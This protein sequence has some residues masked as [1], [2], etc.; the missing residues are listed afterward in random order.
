MKPHKP[1]AKNPVNVTLG[2]SKRATQETFPCPLCVAELDLRSSRS[3]KPYCVCNTCG[4]QV[5]FRGKKGIA[6]L[7]ELVNDRNQLTGA[8]T[9]AVSTVVHAFNRLEHLRAQKKRL[10]LRRRFLFNDDDLETAIRAV[11][12][13]IARV[14]AVLD[15]IADTNKT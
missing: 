4:V 8:A 13:Q 3:E 9:A 6:R 12:N 11:E 7:R 10:E 15:D 1:T 5:F 2:S 14:R